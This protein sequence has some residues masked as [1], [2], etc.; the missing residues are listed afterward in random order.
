[1]ADTKISN[2]T[3]AEALVGTEVAPIVQSGTTKKATIDQILAPIL[4]PQNF[5][6][7]LVGGSVVG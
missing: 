2:L 6:S 7:P 1:M 4:R 5:N 3:S